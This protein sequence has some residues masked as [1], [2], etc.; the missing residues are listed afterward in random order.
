MLQTINKAIYMLYIYIT[1]T[2]YFV[3]IY[4]LHVIYIY[5]Y[6]YNLESQRITVKHGIWTNFYWYKIQTPFLTCFLN[7]SFFFSRVSDMWFVLKNYL[8]NALIQKL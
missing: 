2:H 6:I 4:V 8:L 5:I 3:C 7:F 1:Y